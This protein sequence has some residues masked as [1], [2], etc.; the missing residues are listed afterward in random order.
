MNRSSVPVLSKNCVC[1]FPWMTLHSN[2]VVRWNR[3]LV[4]CRFQLPV[5]SVTVPGTTVKEPSTTLPN[6]IGSLSK[7]KNLCA[8]T[9]FAIVQLSGENPMS[10]L[11]SPVFR[12]Q[13]EAELRLNLCAAPKNMANSTL[14]CQFKVL[15]AGNLYLRAHKEFPHWFQ[16]TKIPEVNQ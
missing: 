7:L 8:R 1:W 3:T 2:T 16:N 5:S 14:E 6:T 13:L 10:H 11:M 4:S 15:K 9:S 12:F